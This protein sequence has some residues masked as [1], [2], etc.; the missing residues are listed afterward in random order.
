MVLDHVAHLAGLV[1]VTP[2]PFDAHLFR[3]GDLYRIDGA[4]IP[5]GGEQRVGETQRQQVQHRL[6]AEIVVDTV[7]LGFVEILRHL[8]VDHAGRRQIGAQRFFHYHARRLM[9][10]LGFAQPFANGAEGAWRHGE[11]VDGGAVFLI[12]HFTQFGK[13]LAVVD[14]Q[15]AE[16]QACAQ[17][18][19]EFVIQ[20]FF[21]EGAK[22]FLDHFGI[23]FFIPL[24]AADA[25]D[26]RIRV[27]VSG[28]L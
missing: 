13:V 2:T 1:E 27:D 11:V 15:I 4:V 20:F 21:H 16:V 12:Q 10:Q 5:V 17:R 9:I 23:R 8:I 26:P 25:D 14:V 6:F 7:N 19:P 24:R 3:H 18:G 28:F 22:R